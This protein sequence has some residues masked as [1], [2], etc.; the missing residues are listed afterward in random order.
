MGDAIKMKQDLFSLTS[1]LPALLIALGFV[2]III[3]LF[4]LVTTNIPGP[5][6]MN[7]LPT[8]PCGGF[9]PDCGATP[10]SLIEVIE[11]VFVAGVIIATLYFV[12]NIFPPKSDF[13]SFWERVEE[14]ESADLRRR[15]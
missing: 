6:P 12:M 2:P 7:T 11:V 15:R 13:S 14:S 8:Q 1:S 3:Y 4:V 9:G 10:V 5:L